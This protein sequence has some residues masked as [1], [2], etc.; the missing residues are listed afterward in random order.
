[1]PAATDEDTIAAIATAPGEGGVCIVRVSGPRALAV[2]DAVFR[3][4]G[5]APSAR[6]ANTVTHGRVVD[7]AGGELDEALLLVFRAPRSYTREDVVELQGHGGGTSAR[8]ILRRVLE[9]GARLAEPG[10]FTR[11]AF[12]NGRIDL[13]QAEAVLDLIRAQSDRASAA[14]LDQLEGALSRRFGELYDEIL[15]A[16]ARVEATLDFPEDG[17]P[18]GLLDALAGEVA[19]ALRRLDALAATWDEGHLLREGALVVISGRPNAGKSTLLNALLGKTR[20]IVSATPGTTRDSLE[21][22][23]TLC[24]IPLRLVDTAGLRDTGCEIEREGIRRARD[25]MERADLHLHVVDASQPTDDETRAHLASLPAERAL[26]VVNKVDLGEAFVAPSGLRIV[27]TAL[28]EGRGVDEL[29]EAMRERLGSHADLSARP[30]AVISE[31]HRQCLLTTR[32]ELAAAGELLARGLED[33]LVPAA[34][35]LRSALG[36]LDRVTGRTYREE[37]LR[38]IFGRFCIGK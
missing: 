6:A 33:R 15:F 26:V 21:E 17:L 16:S 11:R 36:S 25:L 3:C 30:Q 23:L 31:R 34:A 28:R 10:E 19:S 37:V 14:A 18:D 8:R 29:R 7:A 38:E 9:A 2:A 20:A 5:A 32:A 1:M 12:L 22:A 4:P 24:G 35:H 27:R 13:V